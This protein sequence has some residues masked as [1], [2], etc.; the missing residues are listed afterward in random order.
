MV[1]IGNLE[2][3]EQVP[4]FLRGVYLIYNRYDGRV[5]LAQ[6][7]SIY[8]KLRT[9]RQIVKER[10]ARTWIEQDIQ[11]LG[12]RWFDVHLVEAFEDNLSPI[13]KEEKLDYWIDV[14]KAR[15]PERGYNAGTQNIG[16]V[17]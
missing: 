12:E 2:N 9:Y 8:Y 5:F 1:L 13:Q 3:S 16:N 10:S 6:S 17:V 4:P 7:D 11:H 14:F 15:D